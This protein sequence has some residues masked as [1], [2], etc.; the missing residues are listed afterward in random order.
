[1]SMNSGLKMVNGILAEKGHPRLEHGGG[2][3]PG[4]G[5]AANIGSSDRLSCTL[6]GD[7]VNLASRLQ[8][9][10]KQHANPALSSALKPAGE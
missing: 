9:A 6:V 2:I 7:M 10:N 4:N 5:V 8:D 1:M 3:H